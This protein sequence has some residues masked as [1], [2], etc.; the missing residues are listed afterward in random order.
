MPS[1]LGDRIVVF[2][3]DGLTQIMQVNLKI[4]SKFEVITYCLVFT[5]NNCVIVF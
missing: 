1:L 5:R 2:H 3:L 4:A